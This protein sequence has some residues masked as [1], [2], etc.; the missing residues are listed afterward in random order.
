MLPARR[1][2]P[3][4]LFLGLLGQ[5]A[6]QFAL[7]SAQT[8]ITA[9]VAGVLIAFVPV[10]S[11]LL[12]IPILGE[13]LSARKWWG[14]ALAFAGVVLISFG[15]NDHIGLEPMALL[16][17][18]A[19]AASAGYFVLQKPFLTRYSALDLTAYGVWTCMAATSL[20]APELPRLLADVSSSTLFAVVY[21][22]IV[23]TAVGYTLWAY[24]LARASA[25]QV[26]SFL[27][28]EP[29]ATFL[30]AWLL[31]SEV[32]TA[33]AILGAGLAVAG[34]ALVNGKQSD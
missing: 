34:V 14:M 26:S 8:R 11:A 33:A 30:L 15:A 17:L 1:D 2:L 3:A 28:L 5:A 21:L 31:L 7:S 22:G 27:Y 25:S 9:G 12:A 6:Y 16:G 18:L 20:F 10:L 19:A 4:L 24:A 32:P 23:P 13:R 29:V